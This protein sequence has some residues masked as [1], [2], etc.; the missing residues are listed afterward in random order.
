MHLRHRRIAPRHPK[1]VYIPRSALQRSAAC[2]ASRG[3]VSYLF[4]SIVISSQVIK[5]RAVNKY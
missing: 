2:F 4:G 5:R 3:D 1:V